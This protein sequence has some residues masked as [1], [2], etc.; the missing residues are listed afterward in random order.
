[1][2]TDLA[3]PGHTNVIRPPIGLLLSIG[4]LAENSKGVTYPTRLDYFRAKP[5]QLE[6]YADAADKF[7]EVYGEEPAAIDDLLFLNNP[8]DEVLDIRLKAWG[9][10]GIRLVGS[11]N[12]AA[13]EDEDEFL[14]RAWSFEDEVKFFP[15]EEKEVRRELRAEWQGEPIFD[16]LQ[17]PN[18]P[19]VAKL[20]ISLETTLSFCLPRVMGI[21]TVALITTKGRTSTR[22]LYRGVWD[23]QRFF[24]G[25]LIGIPFR[26][27]I[28]KKRSR[29]FDKTKRRYMPT[30]INTLVLKTPLTVA[31]VMAQIKERRESLAILPVSADTSESRALKEALALSPGER[32]EIRDEPETDRPDDALLNRIAQLIDEAGED[33]AI[34][35]LRGVFGKDTVEELDAQE[36]IQY[37]RILERGLSEDAGPAE[38]VDESNTGDG[39]DDTLFDRL[40]ADVKEKLPRQPSLPE[41][42]AAKT[43]APRRKR[44]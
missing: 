12:Y 14:E 31:E 26:L 13:I 21:G 33:A 38:V 16:E 34:V 11:T 32:V 19:R 15:L 9:T 10:S 1:V 36:A 35:T 30:E 23:Q 37:E 18:D 22:N 42:T 28:Q 7:G 39:D 27:E 5:G 29:Y 2:S 17:G 25:Q 40:P 3:T 24:M 6:Q 8:V 20:G 41:K 4:D 44:T 43:T